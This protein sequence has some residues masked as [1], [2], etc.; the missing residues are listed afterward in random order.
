MVFMG[1]DLSGFHGVF[2]PP[3]ALVMHCHGAVMV[4]SPVN[5]FVQDVALAKHFARGIIESQ[6]L[7]VVNKPRLGL[8]CFAVKS[9]VDPDCE[10]TR[11][12]YELIRVRNDDKEITGELWFGLW[13]V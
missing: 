11:A 8:V 6:Y 10:K 2:R 3:C 12:L 9:E 4:S 13:I 5:C 7:E 1:S